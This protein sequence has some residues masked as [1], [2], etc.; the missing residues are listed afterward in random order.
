MS[1]LILVEPMKEKNG[2][3]VRKTKND[4]NSCELRKISLS[5]RDNGYIGSIA[6]STG[7][8]IQSGL[9]WRGKLAHSPIP[10][11]ELQKLVNA[12]FEKIKKIIKLN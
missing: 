2:V 9:S 11:P 3:E 1:S 5:G 4:F 10:I 8:I 6:G 7:N 12:N